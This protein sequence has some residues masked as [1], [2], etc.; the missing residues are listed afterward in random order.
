MSNQLRPDLPLL[1]ARMRSLRVSDAGYPVPW[2]VAWI[3]GK[4]EF[5]VIGPG[6]IR[7]AIERRLCW[8][9][10]KPLGTIMAFVIGP[11]C[12]LNRTNAE[13]PNHP[14]C[15]RFS[16]KGCPFL[17][18][19]KAERREGGMPEESHEPAG[20]AI[21]RNPGC[22]AVWLTNRYAL[23]DDGRGGLLF[24]IGE[25]LA[26]EWYAEGREATHDEV[27]QSV[28]SGYPILET[29]A[30]QEG[31]AALRALAAAKER[32]LPLLPVNA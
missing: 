16:A 3:D 7:L 10:G 13:P 5:R 6:K 11:M 24:E 32:L 20:F 2:F 28:E 29:A 14:D 21:R 22:C 18:R 31:A 23:F 27:L 1:P 19:P 12:G 25:P 17:S 9:C 4:P 30:R 26:V 8:V 15:A